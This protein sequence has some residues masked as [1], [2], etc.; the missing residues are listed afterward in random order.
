[1]RISYRVSSV[2]VLLVFVGMFLL[3]ES[4][5]VRPRAPAKD[6]VEG[7]VGIGPCTTWEQISGFIRLS[8]L[9][10]LATFLSLFVQGLR[11]RT[12][13]RMV[14][15]VSLIAFC[16]GPL[17]QLGRIQYCEADLGI[18]IFWVWIAAVALICVHHIIQRPVTV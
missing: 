6:V 14:A 5:L 3:P 11:N 8:A 16:L 12:V 10:W 1:M 15:I 9:V 2:A 17:D 18:F 7:T 4:L 13:P